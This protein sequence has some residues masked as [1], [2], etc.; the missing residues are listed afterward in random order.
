MNEVEEYKQALIS[1]SKVINNLKYEC[2][3]RL[4]TLNDDEMGYI[5]YCRDLADLI[6]RKHKNNGKDK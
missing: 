5:F 1:I 3:S 6:L 4:Y 2:E